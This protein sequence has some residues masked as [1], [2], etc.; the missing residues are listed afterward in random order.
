MGFTVL[1]PVS[2]L[3]HTI[4]ATVTTYAVMWRA[5]SRNVRI[6]NC[7][8]FAIRNEQRSQISSDRTP[9]ITPYRK[10]NC[11]IST[12][13]MHLVNRLNFSNRRF[14]YNQTDYFAVDNAHFRTLR[15]H[16]PCTKSLATSRRWYSSV[17]IARVR[18]NFYR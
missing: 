4:F 5:Q 8:S 1:Y 3:L 13:T 11:N 6:R 2:K 12:A 16:T 18:H 17:I 15:H 9:L 10:Q 14:G 7:M